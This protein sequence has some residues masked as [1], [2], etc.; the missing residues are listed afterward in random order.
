MSRSICD[1]M[2]EDL[3]YLW[4]GEKGGR[5]RFCQMKGRTCEGP[6]CMAWTPLVAFCSGLCPK[7][8]ECRTRISD[9]AG[10]LDR[11]A[12]DFDGLGF[13]L[14]CLGE[15]LQKRRAR[16]A[17]FPVRRTASRS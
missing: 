15:A 6:S 1:K 12:S 14:V 13:C 10:T 4:D 9:L 5:N 16:R 7:R 11:P 3:P 2:L 8:A 17:C